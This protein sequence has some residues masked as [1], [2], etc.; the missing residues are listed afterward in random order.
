MRRIKRGWDV[1]KSIIISIILG[2][3][4]Y[5]HAD[6]T[7]DKDKIN[8]T[9]D[10]M[11]SC[12]SAHFNNDGALY[13]CPVAVSDSLV[14]LSYKKLIPY[15]Y[16]K[17]EDQYAL[18]KLLAGNEYLGT[19]SKEGS[20]VYSLT[21]GLNKYLTEQDVKNFEIKHSGWRTCKQD[22]HDD[23]NLT[24][25]WIENNIKD[26]HVQWL[27]IG[28]YRKDKD[29]LY[30]FGG[31]WLTV[32]GF[33]GGKCYALDPSGRNGESKMVHRLSIENARKYNLKGETEGMPE[34]S[35]GML[36]IKS[37]FRFKDGADICLIDSSVSL[38]IPP[39]IQPKS[40]K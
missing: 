40:N 25:E 7:Y 27:N 1:K 8:N 3:F 10:L 35:D 19:D 13:C 30:R 33:K 31:H 11:Q 18:V 24:L 21:T 9:P 38:N 6:S 23:A 20:G 16:K 39:L 32:V 26:N 4:L 29:Y 2:V 34:T 36:E 5:A 17:P 14:W 28:W 12:K 22:F 37:G 15:Q